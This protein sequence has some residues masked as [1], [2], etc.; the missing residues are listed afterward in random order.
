[1]TFEQLREFLLQRMSMSHIYQPLVIRTLVEQGGRASVRAI[2]REFLSNDEAQVEYYIRIVKRWPKITLTKHRIIDA[3][4]HGFFRLNLDLASLT[5]I[6][7]AEI[8]GICNERIRGYIEGYRGIIGDYRYN[9]D[10]LSSS[11]IRYLVL[12]LANGQCALCGAIVKDTPL[13]IDH[14][15]PRNRGG[16]NDPSNLQ[17]LCFHWN[18]AKRDRESSVTRRP[19]EPTAK[20]PK[21]RRPDRCT[22][23]FSALVRGALPTLKWALA[24]KHFREAFSKDCSTLPRPTPD[25]DSTCN[26]RIAIECIVPSAV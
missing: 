20:A 5:D 16:S 26:R 13:D 10:D 2:A 19:V 6:Q 8:V 3:S 15:I 4:E 7:R 11:S 25:M 17:A 12:K 1:M 14:I 24:F 23:S 22:T 18:R 9:P 21:N